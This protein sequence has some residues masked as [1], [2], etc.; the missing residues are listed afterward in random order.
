MKSIAVSRKGPDLRLVVDNV[1]PQIHLM[2]ILDVERRLALIER[3]LR[4]PGLV[5]G[6]RE[7]LV[8]M[9]ALLRCELDARPFN[10]SLARRCEH[11]LRWIERRLPRPDRPA[12]FLGR[13]RAV[14][15][16]ILPAPLASA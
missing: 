9:H 15:S 4:R 3:Q 1:D 11:R 7:A 8:E 14:L 12:T 13:A 6:R 10:P 5:A 16:A 2:P